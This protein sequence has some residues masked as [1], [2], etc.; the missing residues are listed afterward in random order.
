[1][2]RVLT[3]AVMIFALLAIGTASAAEKTGKPEV[4]DFDA[5]VIEG[6]KKAPDIFLQ[7]DV[8]KPSIDAVLYQRRHFNDFHAQ[9]SKLRPRLGDSPRGSAPGGARG[10]RAR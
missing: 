9:D 8:Q 5:D 1:M 7:T 4:L 2:N 10:T 6:Q 3:R